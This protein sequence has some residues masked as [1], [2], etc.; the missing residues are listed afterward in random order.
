MCIF[1]VHMPI[2]FLGVWS[3]L[4]LEVVGFWALRK[5]YPAF[6]G[7]PGNLRARTD[8]KGAPRERR[9]PHPIDLGYLGRAFPGMP[10]EVC[11]SGGI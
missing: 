7:P 1:G 9:E 8:P 10:G 6:M 5:F 4:C 3:W 2:G 11:G